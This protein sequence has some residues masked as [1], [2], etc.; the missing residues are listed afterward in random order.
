MINSF[1]TI[2]TGRKISCD[3][4]ALRGKT[5]NDATKDVINN[6]GCN[7]KLIIVNDGVARRCCL[8]D[9]CLL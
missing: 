1:D 3:S 7:F 8:I 2:S 6:N 4:I 9:V 5:R